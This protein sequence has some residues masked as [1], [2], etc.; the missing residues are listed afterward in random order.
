MFVQEFD[1]THNVNNPADIEAVLSKRHRT[2]VNSFWSGQR[3][4]GFPAIAIMVNGDLAHV[5]YFPKEGHP[6][7]ASVGDHWA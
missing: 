1:S 5:H 4:A 3:A 6:G 2:G 7:V